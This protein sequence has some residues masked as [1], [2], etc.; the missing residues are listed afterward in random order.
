[1]FFDNYCVL[2]VATF[3]MHGFNTSRNYVQRLMTSHDVILLQEHMLR[4]VDLC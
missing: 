3:N 1:M 4:D 2:R